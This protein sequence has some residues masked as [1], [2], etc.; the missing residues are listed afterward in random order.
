MTVTPVKNTKE[1]GS[2]P[3]KGGR[4]SGAP[5]L[6]QPAYYI[7]RELSWLEFNRRVLEEARDAGNPL[8]ERVKF[9]SIF[10]S[11]LD[12]FFMIR[13]SGLKRQLEAGALKAPADGLTPARQ[14]AEIRERLLPMLTDLE[15]CWKDDLQ[16]KLFENGIR[17]VSYD[18]LKPKQRR[19]LRELFRNEILPILTPLAFDPGH[20]FPHISNLSINLA[21]MV[22]DPG[23]G[24]R[25]ARLKVPHTLPRLLRVPTGEKSHIQERLGLEEL[26][27]ID[28]VWLE[29]VVTA[30]LDMLFPGLEVT[31]AYPFRVTRNADVEIEEDEAAD[32]LAAMK[33]VVGQRHFGFV[34]RLELDDRTPEELRE[35]LVSN[36]NLSPYQVYSMNGPVGLVDLIQLMSLKRPDLKDKPFQPVVPSCLTN[37]DSIFS[38]LKR[39]DLLLYHPYDSF[40]PMVEFVRTAATDPEV[41]AIKI[42]LYRVGPNSPIVEALKEARQNGKQVSALVELKA[43]FDEENNIEWASALE[44]AGVHVVYGLLGLKTH[45]KMCL[46]VRKE[47][48]GIAR[49]V[50]LGT[51]NYNPVT[52]RVYSDLG[53]LTTD[54]EIASDVTDLFNALT[55]YS[56]QQEYR[57]LL[58]S[59]VTMKTQ[60]LLRI[61]REIEWQEKTGRGYLAFK[62]NAL[63]DKAIIKSLYKA[64]QAGVRVDLQVRGICCL[65]PGVPKVSENI[66]VTSVVGRFLEH[67]RIFYFRN[68]GQEEILLGS[69]D[70]MPRN[71]KGRVETLFPIEDPRLLRSIRDDILGLHM[72]DN[73]KCR[74][75]LADG[76]YIRIKL[77][78]DGVEINS[79]LLRLNEVGSWHL[80]D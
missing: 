58:V 10:H 27:S 7:N 37:E 49:Y 66:L 51:G 35:I 47:R 46:V 65:R 12:E 3:S 74:R 75:L 64:S 28:F 24:P 53:F 54:S 23:F 68:G 8:L 57:K 69:A 52:A 19:L 76:S 50:H 39:R 20:P 78:E 55:G 2:V 36:L 13:V 26:Q 30:N 67:T 16:P 40:V 25:F 9:L 42:T 33:E 17:I 72:K 22:N 44:R 60:L 59:P 11:N 4:S 71:L 15:S 70:L 48:N 29:E 77:N 63:Q 32:L 45:A 43:R 62:L 31:A 6:N 34:I 61:K 14:L 73:V 79:Q 41:L 80:E 5:N 38:I 1:A 21:V 56:R 18:V